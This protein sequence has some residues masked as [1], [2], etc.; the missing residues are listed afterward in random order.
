M[1]KLQINNGMKLA[2]DFAGNSNDQA[3]IFFHG[4]G[5]TRHAWGEA[6]EVLAKAGYFAATVDLRGHG[7][8]DW[9]ED[10]NYRLDAFADDIIKLCAMFD[11]KPI[12][13]GASLGGLSSLLA[14][15]SADTDIARALVLVDIV[16]KVNT[17]GTDHIK[18]F[19]AANPDGF[20][21]LEE[22]AD[23][24]AAYTPQRKRRKDLSGLSKNL[25]L[26]DNGRYYWHWDP[27]FLASSNQINPENTLEIATDNIRVPVLLVRGEKSDVVDDSGVADFLQRIPHAEYVQVSGA[28]HMIAGD[29]NQQFNQVVLEFLNKHK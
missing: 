29:S 12:L 1:I 16:P 4:G 22:A 28:A 15:G 7:H 17:V 27:R 8:S 21:S 19:M 11:H 20:A 13:V 24:I 26:R 5:Q 18:D 23:A 14:I 6:L 9:A 2:I 25:R 10:G 3:V